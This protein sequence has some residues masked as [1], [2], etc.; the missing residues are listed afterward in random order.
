MI[1]NHLYAQTRLPKKISWHNYIYHGYL[2]GTALRIA[3]LTYKN[4]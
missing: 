3:V 1:A 2:R 4:I